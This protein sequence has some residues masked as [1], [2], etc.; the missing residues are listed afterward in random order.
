MKLIDGWKRYFGEKDEREYAE[1]NRIYKTG[2][3]MLTG[4]LCVYLY[5]SL[6]LAQVRSVVTDAMVIDGSTLFILALLLITCLVCAVIQVRKGIVDE[7]VRFS[8]AETFPS[9]YFGLISSLTGVA[10]VLLYMLC[11]D[12]AEAQVLGMDQVHWLVN[13]AMGV[14]TGIFTSF[15]AYLVF[16][17]IFRAA[18]SR[19]KK[20]ADQQR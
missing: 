7:H 14:G 18:K 1:M 19:Q 4:S 10:V 2:F 13:L 12:V 5:Y 9:G 20:L 11:C 6:M 17:C 8:D 15:L 16:Y 3:L